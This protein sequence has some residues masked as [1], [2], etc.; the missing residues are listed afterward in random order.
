MVLG[1]PVLCHGGLLARWKALQYI[2][3]TKRNGLRKRSRDFGDEPFG[4]RRMSF[5]MN[6]NVDS[7]FF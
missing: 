2:H 6:L 3:A 7:R 1:I 4:A 5:L